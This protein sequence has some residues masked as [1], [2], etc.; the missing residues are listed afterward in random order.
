MLNF[1]HILQEGRARSGDVDVF[2]ARHYAKDIKDFAYQTMDM[3]VEKTM[4]S[5][6]AEHPYGAR[7]HEEDAELIH[8]AIKATLIKVLDEIVARQREDEER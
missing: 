1:Q 2:V 8:Q 4:E 5:M 6:P 7:A 3:F